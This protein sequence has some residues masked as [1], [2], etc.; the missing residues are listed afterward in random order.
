MKVRSHIYRNHL[1]T[2]DFSYDD[3]GNRK[4]RP[5][6]IITWKISE[7]VEEQHFVDSNERCDT[8]LYALAVA[9]KEAVSWIDR[10]VSKPKAV[11]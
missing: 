9:L 4:F 11:I 8:G 1:I 5:M 6:A 2:L 10:R 7:G 3:R